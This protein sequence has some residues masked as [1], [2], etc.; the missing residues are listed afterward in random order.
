MNPW[1]QVTATPPRGSAPAHCPECGREMEANW[2]Y[3]PLCNADLRGSKQT[4]TGG[5][6]VDI[7][8]KRDAKGSVVGLG[9][10]TVFGVIGVVSLCFG[11]LGL[12]AASLNDPNFLLAGVVVLALLA[13]GLG[14]LVIGSKARESRAD[15]ELGKWVATVTRILAI[16]GVLF[17]CALFSMI[18]F[19][20]IICAQ[21]L[22][23][24]R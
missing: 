11:G 20:A 7:D 12:V 21:N 9:C 22:T 15:S 24:H 1:Q 2:R 8:I 4:R 18:V 5:A 3:C 13:A 19:F 23:P 6:E 16:A 10:L 17:L 14:G